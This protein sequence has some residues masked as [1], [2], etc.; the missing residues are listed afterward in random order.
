M[1]AVY[2]AHADIGNPLSGLRAADP[3]DPQIPLGLG[4][5]LIGRSSFFR[6]C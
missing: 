1:F 3:P 6:A 5:G 4:E 2:A